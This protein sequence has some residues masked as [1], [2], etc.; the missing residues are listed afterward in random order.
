MSPELIAYWEVLFVLIIISVLAFLVVVILEL[1]NYGWG[2]YALECN[3]VVF[4]LII[5]LAVIPLPFMAVAWIFKQVASW[6]WNNIPLFILVGGLVSYFLLRRKD[7][8]D[9]TKEEAVS[10]SSE[11]IRTL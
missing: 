11:E 5:F 10:G 3:G 1:D 2:R 6:I 7:R 9:Q 8:N 4:L